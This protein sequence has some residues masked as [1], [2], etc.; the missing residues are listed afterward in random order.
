MLALCVVVTVFE[1]GGVQQQALLNESHLSSSEAFAFWGPWHWV[2]DQLETELA[3][4]AL[5]VHTR[6]G[7]CTVSNHSHGSTSVL[8][9][10][11][12]DRDCHVAAFLD[13]GTHCY[14]QC[15]SCTPPA[16]CVHMTSLACPLSS[17][18]SKG[19]HSPLAAHSAYLLDTEA[20]WGFPSMHWSSHRQAAWK[21]WAHMGVTRL[22]LKTAAVWTQE[23]QMR[24]TNHSSIYAIPRYR[25]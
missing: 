24:I 8:P 13:P 14:L 1:G 4:I 2:W 3:L 16:N 21:A 20:Q 19:E 12:H 25:V 17:L 6:H 5:S 23:G 18:L 9:W 22:F 7:G 15:R 11:G 10:H